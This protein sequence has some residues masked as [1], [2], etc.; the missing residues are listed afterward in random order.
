LI[1]EFSF[2]YPNFYVKPFFKHNKNWFPKEKLYTGLLI[3][4]D[5]KYHI[6]KT[7]N[8]LLIILFYI[9]LLNLMFLYLIVLIKLCNQKYEYENEKKMLIYVC[10]KSLSAI[11]NIPYSINI[12]TK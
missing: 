1:K 8:I 2:R 6:Y 5:F 4:N 10:S 3:S 7:L 11:K 12:S 9:L